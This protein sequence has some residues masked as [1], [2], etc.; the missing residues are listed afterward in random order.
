MQTAP[1]AALAGLALSQDDSKSQELVAKPL[2]L[3]FH[4][5]LLFHKLSINVLLSTE[6]P[7]E[8]EGCRYEEY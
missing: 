6:R 1:A 3:I 4:L 2:W 7:C 8:K 5:F